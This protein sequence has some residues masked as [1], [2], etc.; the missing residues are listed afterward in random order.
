MV[1]TKNITLIIIGGVSLVGV[2][3]GAITVYQS[4]QANTATQLSAEDSSPPP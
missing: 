3:A 2:T 4:S 1:I